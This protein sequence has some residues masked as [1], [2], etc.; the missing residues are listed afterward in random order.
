MIRFEYNGNV[1]Y[2]TNLQKKLKRLKITE[3]DIENVIEEVQE[4]KKEDN[5]EECAYLY[6][7]LDKKTNQYLVSLSHKKMSME[8][9]SRQLE[10]YPEDYFTSRGIDKKDLVLLEKSPHG[11]DVIKL[12]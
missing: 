4:K 6:Y 8:E 9:R 5:D 2:T 12:K 3:S 10:E 7:T 11:D 1:Y